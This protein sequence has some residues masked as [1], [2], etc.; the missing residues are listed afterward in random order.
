MTPIF[1]LIKKSFKGQSYRLEFIMMFE[2]EIY[3]III[4]YLVTLLATTPSMYLHT[5][6]LLALTVGLQTFH[7]ARLTSLNHVFIS[8]FQSS[9][10]LNNLASNSDKGK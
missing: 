2:Y 1:S 10:V 8:V 5:H 7:Q 3:L 4:Y 6:V 9:S